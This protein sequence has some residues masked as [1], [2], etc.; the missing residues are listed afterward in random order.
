MAEIPNGFDVNTAKIWDDKA[1]RFM[2]IPAMAER[3][4]LEASKQMD[5][6]MNDADSGLPTP[7]PEY[8]KAY[9]EKRDK[10]IKFVE[11]TMAATISTQLFKEVSEDMFQ[12]FSSDQINVADPNKFGSWIGGFI[13][14]KWFGLNPKGNS[15]LPDLKHEDIMVELKAHTS[16]RETLQVAGITLENVPKE[17]DEQSRAINV[18]AA[19]RMFLKM[20][21]FL[22]VRMSKEDVTTRNGKS[23]RKVHYDDISLHMTLILKDVWNIIFD[24]T[25]STLNPTLTKSPNKVVFVE[26]A[27]PW[28]NGKVVYNVKID[29]N[30]VNGV[31]NFVKLYLYHLDLLSEIKSNDGYRR[32]FFR[33]LNML[34]SSWTAKNLGTSPDFK[35]NIEA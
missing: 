16:A 31:Y 9:T 28:N 34:K 6:L 8:V 24:K 29:L 22:L 27:Q 11:E 15:P 17:L 4:R 20:N 32:S 13:E 18:A 2:T 25:I 30:K 26:K 7:K 10:I 23:Y 21:N 3:L 33:N 19:Y 12:E 5:E 35:I 14:E 1:K